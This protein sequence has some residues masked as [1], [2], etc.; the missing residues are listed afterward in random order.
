VA[1]IDDEQFRQVEPHLRW[2]CARLREL[3]KRKGYSL[4]WVGE[5]I[6]TSHSR[7]SDTESLR[8]DVKLSTVLRIMKAIGVNWIDVLSGAP[9]LQPPLGPSGPT[10]HASI[11]KPP[12]GPLEQK[13]LQP[14]P[15]PYAQ[16]SLQQPP[17]G[18]I[19][20][21]SIQMPPPG[22]LEQ[23][24]LQP[25]TPPPTVLPEQSIIQLWSPPISDGLAEI[26]N[27]AHPELPACTDQE[28][29]L[30]LAAINESTE[31]EALSRGLSV[32]F[33]RATPKLISYM[34]QYANV[35]VN[36]DT[37]TDML[38]RV[39]SNCGDQSVGLTSEFD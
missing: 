10:E 14:P 33:V 27:Q 2:I 31:A 39:Y 35:P 30:R 21:P 37:V 32:R 16:R 38:S 3:R 9:P 20:Q 11:Q 29:R 4:K 13:S 17:P 22:P 6:G 25:P 18:P 36:L 28:A 7:V 24:S 26:V 19:E 15:G 5:K 12:P 23:K 8:Y 1:S 34:L